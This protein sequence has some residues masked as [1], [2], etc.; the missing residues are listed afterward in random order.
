MS[1][2]DLAFK[3]TISKFFAGDSSRASGCIKLG[4]YVLYGIPAR[5]AGE[6]KLHHE[7]SINSNGV[8]TCS[9]TNWTTKKIQS[10]TINLNE[11]PVSEDEMALVRRQEEKQDEDEKERKKEEEE[12]AERLREAEREKDRL[13]FIVP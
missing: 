6:E 10:M 5:P 12:A 11:V 1:K 3:L 7:L 4:D 13:V 8:L 2:N 9:T